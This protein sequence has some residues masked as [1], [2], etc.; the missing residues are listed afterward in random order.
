MYKLKA[1]FQ[2]PRGRNVIGAKRPILSLV[3]T[4]TGNIIGEVICQHGHP[5]LEECTIGVIC[6]FTESLRGYERGIYM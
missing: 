4:I 2:Y 3:R 6:R 5:V 1:N